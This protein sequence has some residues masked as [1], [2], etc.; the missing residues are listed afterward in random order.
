M[1]SWSRALI[2]GILLAYVPL[3]SAEEKAIRPDLGK[4]NDG[5]T[6][7][8]VNADANPAVVDGK[9]LVRLYPKGGNTKGSNVGMA[10]VDGL[11]FAEGTLEVDLK[12]N[13]EKQASF[14]GVA[15]G[16]ADG[17]TFEAVYFR[18]FN[19]RTNDPTYQARAVQYVAW[20]ENTWEK[21]RMRTPGVYES[22]VNPIPDP[23]DWFHARIEVGKKKVSV[24][25]NGAKK[26][27]LVVNRLGSIEKGKVGLW[28]D[29]RESKF[30][31]LKIT[32]AKA[33]GNAD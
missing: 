26:P 21:L 8:V 30:R 11:E 27:C 7:S 25:V 3:C 6:W 33:A 22:A 4:I 19:F 13:G 14:L 5:K 32:R 20:P 18:P 2:L 1:Y 28:V 12:G 10:L 29:S 23:T 17:K 24:F 31:N 15:F 16:V 9:S